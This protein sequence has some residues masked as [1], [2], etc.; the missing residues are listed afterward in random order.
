M[1]CGEASSFS[2][3]SSCSPRSSRV[4]STGRP[5]CR[6]LYPQRIATH[7][8]TWVT[9]PISPVSL[10]TNATTW[11]RS[12]ICHRPSSALRVT[13]RAHHLYFPSTPGT[14]SAVPPLFPCYADHLPVSISSR[15]K[16]PSKTPEQNAEQKARAKRRTKSP[17][18]TPTK[19]PKENPLLERRGTCHILKSLTNTQ[20][21]GLFQ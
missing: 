10:S 9:I 14:C 1:E 8:G 3:V 18:E 13:T 17:N 2:S 4:N 16:S 5:A 19:S 11:Q 20:S 15:A 12:S 21:Y 7:T 6:H